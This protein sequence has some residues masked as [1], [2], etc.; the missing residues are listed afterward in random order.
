MKVIWTEAFL[1]DQNGW[2]I[3]FALCFCKHHTEYWFHNWCF[4]IIYLL[5]CHATVS[6]RSVE[7]FDIAG[8]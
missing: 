6:M 1:C 8:M 3:E 2:R 5:L 7:Q 4:S